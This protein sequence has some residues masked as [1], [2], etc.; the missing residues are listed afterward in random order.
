MICVIIPSLCRIHKRKF[1]RLRRLLSHSHETPQ[2]CHAGRRGR[3]PLLV[4][5]TFLPICWGRRLDAPWDC[6][7]SLPPSRMRG[8]NGKRS[9]SLLII[10]RKRGI[11]YLLYNQR[12]KARHC[13]PVTDVTGVAIRPFFPF[14]EWFRRREYGFPRQCV[15]WLGMTERFDGLLCIVIQIRKDSCFHGISF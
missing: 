1:W 14:A 2:T 10:A 9:N 6:A 13:E 12:A 8:E 4:L 15:H 5:C 7:A 11:L 3:R